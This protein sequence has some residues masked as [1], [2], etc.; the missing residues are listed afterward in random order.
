MMTID[1][2]LEEYSRLPQ[3]GGKFAEKL[4]NDKA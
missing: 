2:F 1:L 3:S 4:A